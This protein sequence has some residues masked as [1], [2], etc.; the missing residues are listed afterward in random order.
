MSKLV[1]DQIGERLFEIGVEKGVLFPYKNNAYQ[2]GVAWNGLTGVNENPEGGDVSEQY[3][4]NIN[5]LNLISVEKFKAT[6]EAFT[7]PDEFAECDGSASLTEGVT[8]GQQRRIPFG[9]S[10]VTRIG[11]D[12]DGQDH[13]YTIHLVYGCLASPS[14]KDYGT[15]NDNLDPTTFSWEVTS[16]PVPVTGLK[17]TAHLKIDSTKVDATK[18]AAF[19]ETLY[20]GTNKEPTLLMPDA[21]LA[22][23]SGNG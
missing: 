15:I 22:A 19:E 18:L 3:A 8:V 5:Y 20:G 14:S 7:Y 21:V 11:N 16:T 4:D 10:Y 1:W 6:I 2:T 23:F 17:P 13:G 12:T 9:F